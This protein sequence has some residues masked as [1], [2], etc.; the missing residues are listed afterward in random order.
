MGPKAKKNP[1][2]GQL[3]HKTAEVLDRIKAS[4]KIPIRYLVEEAVINYLPKKY[5]KQKVK[6][7][8]VS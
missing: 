4:T 5:E 6:E 1:R 2:T 3:T 8:V 7:E